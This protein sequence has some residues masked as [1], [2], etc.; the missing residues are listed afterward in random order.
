MMIGFERLR[1]IALETPSKI[2]LLVLDGLGGLPDPRSGKTELETAH[3]PSL[4]Q[5]AAKSICGM[6]DPVS[7]GI[8]PGSGPAHLALFG[9]DPLVYDIGRGV[10]ETLGIDFDLREQDLA[11]RGNF[12]TID[13]KGLVVDRRAGRIPT[14]KSSELCRL[15]GEIHLDGVQLFVNPVKEHRFAVVFR[16]EGLSADLTESDPQQAGLA[17]M[18]IKALAPQAERTAKVVNEFVEKARAALARSH[19]ANMVLMRGFSKYPNLPRMGEVYKLTPAAIATYPMYRGLAKL[20]GMKVL[21]TGEGVE[22]EFSTLRQHYGGHDF[23]YVHVKKT[24]AAG[25]DGNF[26]AK[27]KAIEEIDAHLPQLLDL[28]PDVLIVT[29]DHSTPALLAG[30]SWHP[31]P[32]LLYSRWV[33][34]DGLSAFSERACRGGSLGRTPAAE[35]MPLAMAYAQKL[36]KFGA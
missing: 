15:L 24:D 22:A 25:E 11:V 31:V 5:L 18:T 3:T 10:L 13:E 30:H 29:G 33:R 7:P 20:V 26:G 12:C 35:L 32:V 28:A 9:Y 34:P 27:V 16:G 36:N 17:P 23:F 14:E 6:H 1:E 8:T 19:T 2:V 21:A 4:D